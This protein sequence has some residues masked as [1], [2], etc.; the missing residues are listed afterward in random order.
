MR[1]RPLWDAIRAHPLPAGAAGA[2][3]AEQLAREHRISL[4]TAFRGIEEYRRF[5][6][7]AALD[8]GR[9]VP[10]RAVDA[11]W[12]LHLT[13][14]RDYWT[15][16]VPGALGGR[17]VHHQPGTPAGHGGDYA[18][19][20]RRYERE[21]GEA[22]P[23]GI[24]SHRSGWGGVAAMAFGAVWMMALVSIGQAEGLLLLSL[25][26][27]VSGGCIFILGL[28]QAVPALGFEFGIDIWS[29]SEGG[30]CGD[31]GGGCGD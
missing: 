29:D 20:I 7:L 26:G 5:I 14:T 6:Y 16:F 10:S 28:S 19:T 30:D 15:R 31:C 1:N 9:S 27:L 8:E 25:F 4:T 23:K 21:F 3:F 22:P 2:S 13:H 24:W 17:P 11:V 12:H 18:D